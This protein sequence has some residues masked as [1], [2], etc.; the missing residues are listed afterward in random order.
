MTP[1]EFLRR[2]TFFQ[3]APA[4]LRR[5]ARPLR[6][7]TSA[8]A[9]RLPSTTDLTAVD[10]FRK[11]AV[12]VDVNNLIL[13]ARDAGRGFDPDALGRI[14]R[15]RCPGILGSAAMGG[16][17]PKLGQWREAFRKAGFHV[18]SQQAQ[19][20]GGRFKSDLDAVVGGLL[21]KH[22][23]RDRVGQLV[24]ASGDS[25]FLPL[26]R[27]LR[28]LRRQPV[29]VVV[30]AVA[31]SLSRALEQEADATVWLGRDVLPSPSAA[32]ATSA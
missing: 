30:L 23:I 19:F 6:L 31:G 22:L 12:V 7:P 20:V 4:P 25:D 15:Q 32:V 16:H 14:L 27:F 29:R 26:I 18:V 10:P 11:S 13:S 5:A 3:P 8:R 2:L 28:T 9:D 17:E 21:T 24:L 1:I